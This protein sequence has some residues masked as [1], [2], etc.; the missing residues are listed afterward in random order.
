[1]FL[2]YK[3]D[4]RFEPGKSVKEVRKR[5]QKSVSS[6]SPKKENKKEPESLQLSGS[7]LLC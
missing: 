7:F 1:V 5:P 2:K 3:H 4:F 6:E